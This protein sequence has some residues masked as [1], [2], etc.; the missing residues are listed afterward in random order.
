MNEIRIGNKV[1]ERVG[2]R[3]RE[4][5][6]KPANSEENPRNYSQPDPMN[7][8]LQGKNM[9]I[10]LTNGKVESGICKRMGQYYMEIEREGKTILINKGSIVEVLL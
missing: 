8:S 2:E 1:F 9:T 7:V 5:H 3:P 4:P 10:T 6:S